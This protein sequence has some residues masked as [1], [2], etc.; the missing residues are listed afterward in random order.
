MLPERR[1]I[2]ETGDFYVKI[3]LQ[4]QLIIVNH[5]KKSSGNLYTRAPKPNKISG[6]KLRVWADARLAHAVDR[7]DKKDSPRVTNE[8]AR[9]QGAD[10]IKAFYCKKRNTLLGGLGLSKKGEEAEATRGMKH[11]LIH[12]LLQYGLMV[13]EPVGMQKG[14]DNAICDRVNGKLQCVAA[15]IRTCSLTKKIDYVFNIIKREK[16][17]DSPKFFH[18]LC[19]EEKDE[20]RPTF[21]VIPNPT[22]KVLVEAKMK[23]KSS[24]KQNRDYGCHLSRNQLFEKRWIDY[25]NRFD[26]I[27]KAL[28]KVRKPKARESAEYWKSKEY[29]KEQQLYKRNSETS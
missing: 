10:M 18:I 20:L 28:G 17:V 15:Q 24:W 23:D 29:E 16:F 26:L 21:L 5:R 12:S 14:V 7:K 8:N 6:K 4:R 22:L 25:K 1:Y 3:N 19:L 2:Q 13:F 11:L 27:D 9:A